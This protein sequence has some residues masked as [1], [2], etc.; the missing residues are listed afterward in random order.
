[1]VWNI[2]NTNLIAMYAP[3]QKKC[4]VNPSDLVP[5]KWLSKTCKALEESIKN[6]FALSGFTE[7]MIID[8]ALW[9]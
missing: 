9:S 5:L 3:K 7:N 6:D 2:C 4:S 1:M 8:R